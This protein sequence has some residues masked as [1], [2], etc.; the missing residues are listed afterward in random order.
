MYTISPINN[1]FH[2]WVGQ[3]PFWI[4]QSDPS[5]SFT[6]QCQQPFEKK[7]QQ[8]NACYGFPWG[9]PGWLHNWFQSCRR[10]PGL[11][12][13]A[14]SSFPWGS[15]GWFHKWFQS[16]WSCLV[17]I[18]MDEFTSFSYLGGWGI[19]CW[20]L[21]TLKTYNLELKLNSKTYIQLQECS[22]KA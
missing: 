17:I 5:V 10:S 9:S 22:V 6:S 1:I 12:S 21:F 11:V 16:C 2:I 20:Q 8:H 4:M 15:P 18:V 13:D 3:H 14:C 19:F 7:L